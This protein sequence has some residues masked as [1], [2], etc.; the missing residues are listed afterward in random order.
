V[1]TESSNERGTTAPADPVSPIT[2]AP[3]ATR[4]AVTPEPPVPAAQFEAV[5]GVPG[6]RRLVL[7]TSVFTNPDIRNDF[8]P[9]PTAAL[10][11]FLALARRT[12]GLEFFMPPSIWEEL[13]TFVD[14]KAMPGDTEL[15]I[16]RKAPNKYELTVPAFLLYELIDDVRT[17]VDKGL[18]LAE[19]AARG[20]GE[21][22]ERIQTLR[23]KYREALREGIIDS[24]EDVELILL[25]KE[26]HGIV[27]SADRGVVLW[28]EKLG[29]RWIA[30]Q[31]L[32]GL[33]ESQAGG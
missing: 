3:P 10:N 22:Q 28:A 1:P 9:T 14:A 21:E 11:A 30:P 16:Q 29:L 26:L 5:A 15:I 18:R 27:V 2:A 32:K 4:T 17:R 8:G 19:D 33:L 13:A 12:R 23:K 25:A 20:A 24:T 31:N 7:D 6:L